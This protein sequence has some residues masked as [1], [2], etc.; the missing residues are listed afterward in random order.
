MQRFPK[1]K[2]GC[3]ERLYSISCSS[4]IK[5]TKECLQRDLIKDEVHLTKRQLRK[6]TEDLEM[7]LNIYN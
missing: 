5:T 4:N 3:G 7:D 6:L 1:V 2:E